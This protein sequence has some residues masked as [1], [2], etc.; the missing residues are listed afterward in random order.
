MNIFKSLCYWN[1]ENYFSVFWMKI[2]WI[3]LSIDFCYVTKTNLIWKL[4]LISQ[5][6]FLYNNCGLIASPAETPEI[7]SQFHYSDAPSLPSETNKTFLKT[8]YFLYCAVCMH[9]LG[10]TFKLCHFYT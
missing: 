9:V 8:F 3:S 4:A 10:A 6:H 5:G 1:R 7:S 2:Q